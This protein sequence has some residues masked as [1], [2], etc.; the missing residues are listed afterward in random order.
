MQHSASTRIEVLRSSQQVFN[1]RVYLR[2]PLPH[3]VPRAFELSP[4]AGLH[5]ETY[6]GP[7]TLTI[8]D[9]CRQV[10]VRLTG[11]VYPVDGRYHWRGTVFDSLS[12]DLLKQTL[13][14]TLAAG[15]RSAAARITEQTPQGTYSIAGIGAPPF[16]VNDVELAV[17]QA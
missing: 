4:S 16:A 15:A 3:P 6:D 10:H 9:A 14:V 5:D 11:H 7:A 2:R 8:A 17:P 1:E 12:A 13:Q